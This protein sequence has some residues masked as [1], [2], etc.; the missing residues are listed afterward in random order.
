VASLRSLWSA[1]AEGSRKGHF[2]PKGG[3]G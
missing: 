3:T 1:R 2:R